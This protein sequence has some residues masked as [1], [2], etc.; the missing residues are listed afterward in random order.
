[1]PF[2]LLVSVLLATEAAGVGA[3][4]HDRL[5]YGLGGL[6]SGPVEL[7]IDLTTGQ[8]S[9]KET[10]PVKLSDVHQKQGQLDEIT[11][12]KLKR[13]AEVAIRIGF[14]TKVCRRERTNH[15]FR[16]PIMDALPAMT[17][18]IGKRWESAPANA[19]CWSQAAENLSD[20]ALNAAHAAVPI[21]P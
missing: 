11:V 17:V 10:T 21:S 4:Q 5:H 9:L 2:I 6:M 20:E 12:A 7:D 14:E 18:K 8:F 19:G 15:I 1:M 3:V 13:T 16:M